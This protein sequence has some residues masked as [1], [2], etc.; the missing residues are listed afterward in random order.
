MITIPVHKVWPNVV[1]HYYKEIQP[2]DSAY[3]IWQWVES[4][5]S[6]KRL[7]SGY[8]RLTAADEYDFVFDSE[9]DATAFKLKFFGPAS[10]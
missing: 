7:R 8:N 2:N 10:A 4:E 9:E 6:G 1:N 5:Y 3:S